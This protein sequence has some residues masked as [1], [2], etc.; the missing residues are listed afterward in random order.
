MLGPYHHNNGRN[1]RSRSRSPAPQGGRRGGQHHSSHMANGVGAA[2]KPY[3]RGGGGG[4]GAGHSN[5]GRWQEYPQWQQSQPQ[6]QQLPASQQLQQGGLP[7]PAAAPALTASASSSSL[8]YSQPPAQ[9]LEQSEEAASF[10]ADGGVGS[11]GPLW[12]HLPMS[13]WG[14]MGGIGGGG[15]LVRRFELQGP[16]TAAAAAAGSTVGSTAGSTAAGSGGPKAV[17]SGSGS[18]SG[19]LI[20]LTRLVERP[21]LR[22]MQVPSAVAPV[23]TLPWRQQGCTAPCCRGRAVGGCDARRLL[24]AMRREE[25]FVAGVEPVG[26]GAG[27]LDQW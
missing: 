3:Y 7:V 17:G 27:R 21:G 26:P 4:G 5:G 2:S 9:Q 20:Q 16:S 19:G 25:I 14:A 22:L 10:A 12:D 8:S 11:G 1:G 13:E 18:G 24:A 23:R 6:P 15:G